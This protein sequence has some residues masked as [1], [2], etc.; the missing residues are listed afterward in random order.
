MG[1]QAKKKVDVLGKTTNK[2]HNKATKGSNTRRQG[3]VWSHRQKLLKDS[4]GKTL[5]DDDGNDR[6]E[7]YQVRVPHRAQWDPFDKQRY[8]DYAQEPFDSLQL[9]W[10][11]ELTEYALEKSAKLGSIS[12]GDGRFLH[13]VFYGDN[14][15]KPKQ[16]LLEVASSKRLIINKGPKRRPR[17]GS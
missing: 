2:R 9:D 4:K 11:E 5:K 8:G 14:I 12:L 13:R 16:V 15:E 3:P 7:T 1:K 17:K 6:F 10:V